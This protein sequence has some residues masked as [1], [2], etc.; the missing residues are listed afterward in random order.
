MK[1]LKNIPSFS[2]MSVKATNKPD[3]LFLIYNAINVI[4]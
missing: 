2:E 1:W 3:G 4:I